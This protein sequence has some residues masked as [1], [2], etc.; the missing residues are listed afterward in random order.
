MNVR[1]KLKGTA[2]KQDSLQT[3][4]IIAKVKNKTFFRSDVLQ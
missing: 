1:R 3:I 4:V 2:R